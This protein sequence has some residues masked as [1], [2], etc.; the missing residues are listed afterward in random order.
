MLHKNAIKYV[1][2][3]SQLMRKILTLEKSSWILGQSSEKLKYVQLKLV[4]MEMFLL[5]KSEKIFQI[6]KFL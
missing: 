3:E 4:Q 5:G 6:K 1:K 2:Q